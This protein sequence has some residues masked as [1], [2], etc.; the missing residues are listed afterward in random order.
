MTLSRFGCLAFA[1]TTSLLLSNMAGADETF[2]PDNIIITG[3]RTPIAAGDMSTAVTVIGRAELDLRQSFQLA[4]VLRDVPGL[5]VAR[6]GST[7]SQA[8]IR[9]RGSEANHV[10]VLIDG[11]EA[12]DPA[13][14][15][16]FL[17][18]HLSAMEV[19]RIEVI[20]GPQSAL[21]GSDAVSGVINIVTR[22]GVEG[23]DGGMTFE[24][25]SFDTLRSSVRV[26]FGDEKWRF[27][28]GNSHSESDGTNV[29]RTGD[30]DDG[31]DLD[32]VQARLSFDPNEAVSFDFTARR[33]EAS[34]EF[35]P[36][37]YF[38][39]GLPADGDR[40]NEAERNVY[41]ASANIESG[42]WIHKLSTNW[43]E[44]DNR[45]FADGV[46]E[47]TV[48]AERLKVSYQATV[49]VSEGHRLTGAVDHRETDFTQTGAIIWGDPN[50]NQSLT[51][52]GYVLDYVGELEETF[53]VT[54][55]VRYD[56]NSDFDNITTW[57]LGA[58]YD[59]LPDT[60]L[61]GSYGLGQ[62]APT[63]IERY[64][65]F[66]GSFI[67][68]P[69]LKPEISTSYEI[70]VDHVAAD[71]R[72]L[73][74]LTYFNAE[75]EDE[76]D[77]FVW[78]NVNFA[79]TAANKV[80]ESKRQGIEATMDAQLSDKFDL[81]VNYTWTDAEEPDGFGGLKKELRRPEHAGAVALTYGAKSGTV[82]NVNA[83]YVGD[84]EDVFFPPWP[85]PSEIVT[86]DSYVLVT[87]SV[88]VPITEGAQLFARV[89]NAF[90]ASYEDVFG[91]ATPGAAVYGGLRVS[92]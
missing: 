54:A 1:A 75:L 20:R 5:T 16:E 57:R 69:D 29:A 21:W 87:A 13:S 84:A 7:G 18:E 72:V 17:F 77:G 76:I 40:V 88:Q 35:D 55:S 42:R 28:I 60:R 67:G 6:S 71:G 11:V 27:S 58:S 81:S 53:T 68:N 74:G 50:Q 24:G 83:A 32:T 63:F 49:E 46:R 61:R 82:I 51:N 47:G 19:E 4:D 66:S 86:L 26:G 89:E 56:D 79:F 91:F 9:M 62:K 31:Y 70:G 85:M 65:F 64:G 3:V 14:G 33:V 25:G 36:T 59:V 12:N 22:R 10:L 92:F 34:N 41:G 23:F 78:D 38:V 8:Q 2:A 39:T 30:E 15:D 48:G 73:L 44:S 80:G 43:L 52:T 45:S 90:D 37:D